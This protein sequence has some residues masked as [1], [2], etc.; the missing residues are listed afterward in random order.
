MKWCP[1]FCLSSATTVAR[2]SS[3]GAVGVYAVK[4][5]FRGYTP[6]GGLR[7]PGLT[8]LPGFDRVKPGQRR[9]WWRELIDRSGVQGGDG[10]GFDEFALVES[11]K[12]AASGVPVSHSLCA[13]VSLSVPVSLSPLSLFPDEINGV[14]DILA[15]EKLDDSVS[16]QRETE[17]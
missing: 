9:G 16:E 17:I 11:W 5:N 12:L 10:F 3:P 13:P 1:P 7:T 4:S 6:T 14:F 2:R 8:D 15:L